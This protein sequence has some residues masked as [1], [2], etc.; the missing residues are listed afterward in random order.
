MRVDC[1]YLITAWPSPS[2]PALT[3]DEHGILGAVL[4]I[5]LRYPILPS[6]VL[7]GSLTSQ[8]LPLPT[9]ALQPSRMQNASEFWQSLG[10][11]LK[12]ALSFTV[13][14]SVQPIDSFVSGSSVVDMRH[15]L[16][17]TVGVA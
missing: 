16:S 11:K 17:Q 5:L 2:A 7:Q 9:T 6:V 8:D 15:T 4:Q 10:G 3:V 1:S 14:I 13:T 12:V